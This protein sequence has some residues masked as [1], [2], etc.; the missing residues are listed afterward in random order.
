VT[1]TAK[2]TISVTIYTLRNGSQRLGNAWKTLPPSIASTPRL[3]IEFA[4]KPGQNR[5][6]TWIPWRRHNGLSLANGVPGHRHPQPES[7]A[8]ETKSSNLLEPEDWLF[9]YFSS[10]IENDR[11]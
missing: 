1:T 3:R 11:Q 8:K 2:S 10:G 4:Q 6:E 5:K 9:Y 7:G